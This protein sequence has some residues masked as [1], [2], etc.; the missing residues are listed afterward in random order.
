MN[1]NTNKRAP[2]IATVKITKNEVNAALAAG[3]THA[4]FKNKGVQRR[5]LKNQ[6]IVRKEQ[7]RKETAA[8]HRTKFLK[9]AKEAKDLITQPAASAVVEDGAKALLS[10]FDGIP[11][12]EAIAAN[13]AGTVTIEEDHENDTVTIKSNVPE[14]LQEVHDELV[15]TGI[16]SDIGYGQVDV[17]HSDSN[18]GVQHQSQ[19]DDGIVLSAGDKLHRALSNIPKYVI[20]NGE[21][22]LNLYGDESNYRPF[23]EIGDSIRADGIVSAVRPVEQDPSLEELKKMVEPN[24]ITDKI[25]YSAPGVVVDNKDDIIVQLEPS[26]S[27]E[28][29]G[30]ASMGAM[31]PD[32]IIFDLRN[33]KLIDRYGMASMGEQPSTLSEKVEAAMGDRP[34]SFSMQRDPEQVNGLVN[35]TAQAM[36]KERFSIHPNGA[37]HR[38][39]KE[40]VTFSTDHHGVGHTFDYDPPVHVAQVN[41]DVEVERVAT[42]TPN[43]LLD[44]VVVVN[45]ETGLKHFGLK[46]EVGPESV[47]HLNPWEHGHGGGRKQMYGNITREDILND[48]VR[49]SYPEKM[50]TIN[51]GDD[52]ISHMYLNGTPKLDINPDAVVSTVSDEALAA[53]G[54]EKKESAL[55]PGFKLTDTH[56]G[57]GVIPKI[58]PDDEGDCA[59]SDMS[60]A[61][62]NRM[63]HGGDLP[64]EV[65][66]LTKI[67]MANTLKHLPDLAMGSFDNT[68]KADPSSEMKLGPVDEEGNKPKG[69]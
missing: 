21:V 59:A 7:E 17:D 44:S 23:P 48:D 50:A 24:I 45:H 30:L 16:V 53:Y 51:I 11:S 15:A 18:F 8:R 2:V 5:L 33:P 66:D 1:Q 43:A 36:L 52:E 63:I 42:G 40:I 25:T 28:S 69:E 14:F 68:P 65:S 37:E 31:P 46:Q 20:G 13:E 39:L 29:Q 12:A 64:A 61:E 19:E 49:H 60:E 22:A 9:K 35:P 26:P 6:E 10:L 27:I 34:E 58:F 32:D 57:S 3:N 47:F 67:R 54:I 56:G 4:S 55:T 38:P 62:T 41:H